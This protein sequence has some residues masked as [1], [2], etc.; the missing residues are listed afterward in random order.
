MKKFASTVIASAMV[1]LLLTGCGGGQGAAGGSASGTASGTPAALASSAAAGGTATDKKVVTITRRLAEWGTRDDNFKQAVAR[2]NE[3]LAGKNVEVVME[4]WPKVGDDELLLQSQAGKKA[5]IFINSSVDIG[6]QQEA[7]IIRDVDWVKESKLFATTSE[8]I[9]NIMLFNGHY[10][11]VVQ[12]MD[13]S[14]VFMY[15]EHL[16][17]LGMTDAQIDGLREQVN[18]GEFTLTDLSDLAKKALDKGLVELGFTVEDKRFQGWQYAYGV[19]NYDIG[20]NKLVFD[21]NAVKNLYGF[22]QKGLSS[23][24]ISE[25]IGDVDTDLSAPKFIEGKVF[26]SF[27][28]TEYYEKL[29]TA[30]GMAEDA[31]G[32]DA[33]F[34]QNVVWTAVPSAEK[35]GKPVSFSNPAMIFVGADVDEEKMPYV[36]RVI[37]LMMSPDLQIAHTL[38]SGKLPVT[39]E[40]LSDERFKS[41]SYYLDQMYM[42]D[43]TRVRSP[44]AYYA[45]FIDGYIA[46]VDTILVNKQD[47]GAAYEAYLKDAQQN[48]PADQIIYN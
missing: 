25:S 32:F 2:M 9:M 30:K 6:W 12:D 40:A 23:G 35:G 17:Q 20:K 5:D 34:N 8:N 42:T 26:A 41:M 37:E 39:P 16:K 1:T 43:F 27:A 22:W 45:K 18:K 31:A 13:T 36:Q 24:V 29:R 15:R 14:P 48:I 19:T 33:W 4:E 10:Y 28:R 3:E 21:A 47:A 38:A 11:G 46:G 44:H 7:G